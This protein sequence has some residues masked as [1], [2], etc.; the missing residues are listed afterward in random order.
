MTTATRASDLKHILMTR[1]KEVQDDIRTR[2]RGARSAR[3]HD[4]RDHLEHSDASTQEDLDLALVQ[5][6]ADTLIRIDHA[7]AR[8]DAG[9]YGSC[10]ECAREIAERRLRALP[11]AVR[12]QTCEEQCEQ[13]YGR[14]RLAPTGSGLS[15]FSETLTPS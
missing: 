5:M 10:I 13:E 14:T 4:G 11:F 8:L 6:R 1:R 15:L 3:P 12:C 7:L 9:K 2:V